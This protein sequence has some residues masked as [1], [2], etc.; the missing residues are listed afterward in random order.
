MSYSKLASDFNNYLIYC[1]R[2]LSCF[3]CQEFNRQMCSQVPFKDRR[4]A[5]YQKHNHFWTRSAAYEMT[6]NIV[7][8]VYSELQSKKRPL[9]Q[10]AEMNLVMRL[11]CTSCGSGPL[12]EWEQRKQ[13]SSSQVLMKLNF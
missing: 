9:P 2:S 13:L 3:C 4:V 1:H 5:V 7:D 10:L 12:L 8:G 6:N 11:I